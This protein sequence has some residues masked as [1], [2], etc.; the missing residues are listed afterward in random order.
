[1]LSQGCVSVGL[2]KTTRVKGEPLRVAFPEIN[3]PLVSDVFNMCLFCFVIE[4]QQ[5]YIVLKKMK[6]HNTYKFKTYQFC[7]TR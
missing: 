4:Y 5:C 7:V 6:T 3:I 2:I 1:M